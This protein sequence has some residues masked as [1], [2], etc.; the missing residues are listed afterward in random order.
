MVARLSRRTILSLIGGAAVAA[1]VPGVALAERR[2]RLPAG[3]VIRTVMGD[4][5]PDALS[6]GA[7]L[8]HEHLSLG[9]DFIPKAITL[10]RAEGN[11]TVPKETVLGPPHD[12]HLMLAELAAA[13]REGVA[14]IVDAGHADMGRDLKFLKQ[15]STRSGMPIVAGFGFYAEPF[16]PPLLAEWSE[17]QIV[18]ELVNQARSQPVGVFGEIG[19]WHDMS[20][21]ERKVFRAVGRAHLETN[22]PIFTHTDYG[23]G[24]MQQL[25]LFEEIG[26]HPAR[27]VIGHVGGL[28]DP[29]ADVAMAICKRGAFVGYDRQ[30]GPG[31]SMQLPAVLA[32][33]EAGFA[34]NLLFASDFALAPDLQRNGGPGYAK[35]LTVFVPKLRQAGV[36]EEVLKRILV[37]NPRRFL[38]CIPKVPR[39]G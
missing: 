34:D 8:F 29:R 35:T 11:A 39:G 6:G 23:K 2:L 24:A 37:D 31:D 15:P 13:R 12:L 1:A 16:Y 4:L 3:T 30:G 28:S 9:D 18:R 10:L 22:L 14:C 5:N 32:L 7:T 17:A 27:V 21:L 26:V 36:S 38:A 20:D 19:T 33:L 25:D